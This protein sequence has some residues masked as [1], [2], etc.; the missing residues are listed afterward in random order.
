MPPP[1]I[2][3]KLEGNETHLPFSNFNQD[4]LSKTWR[5]CTKVKDALENGSRL[6]NLSWRLWFIQNVVVSNDVKSNTGTPSRTSVLNKETF[7]SPPPP[8]SAPLQTQTQ[9]EPESILDYNLDQDK[10][11]STENFI[12]NQFT[13][14]QQGDQMIELKD[15]FPFDYMYS[16]PE[17]NPLA[18]VDSPFPYNTSSWQPTNIPQQP[19]SNCTTTNN[20]RFYPDNAAFQQNYANNMPFL[21]DQYNACAINIPTDVDMLNQPNFFADYNSN[22]ALTS[23]P[24][25]TLH[26][27]LLATLPRQTLASAER[28]LSKKPTS[29]QLQQQKMSDSLP[30][31][32][33]QKKQS[34]QHYYNTFQLDTRSP[35]MKTTHL[36]NTNTTPSLPDE[37]ALQCSNCDATT[38]PL[39][40]RSA[41]DKILCNACGLYLKLHN[42]PRPKNLKAM[43][44]KSKEARSSNSEID[45]YD[46]GNTQEKSET[47]HT[48]CS[49]CGTDKTP[50]WRRDI[51]GLP[52]CNACGLYLKL[53]NEKRPLSMK[54]DVIKKRQ[55]T[56]TLLASSL[57]D[58]VKKPRYYDQQS[59]YSSD[60][61]ATPG[62]RNTVSSLPGTG[63]LMMTPSSSTTPP[64]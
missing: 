24:N 43:G 11:I 41:E 54:T 61:N 33:S 9:V 49:N 28:L 34:P 6:E 1:P 20:N 38:T 47:S 31:N 10:Q 27:K 60:N 62:Y 42:A 22:V 2:V 19:Y 40:R 59:L 3:L 23:I 63:I 4:E 26:N 45:D 18:Q 58:S 53:H 44:G 7:I 15:I 55:R 13:S 30:L 29:H 5:L 39:W 14:D 64:S 46:S 35:I 52:L 25:A 48:I 8:A 21:Q 16:I 37:K 32:N 12:L 51:E 57:D 50:L 17:E 36:E 56:E